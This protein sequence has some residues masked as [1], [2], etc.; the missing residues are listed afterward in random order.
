MKNIRKAILYIICIIFIG[1]SLFMYMYTQKKIAYIDNVYL[2]EHSKIK[3]DLYEKL[4]KDQQVR[5]SILDTIKNNIILVENKLTNDRENKE[6]L[7]QYVISKETFLQKKQKF[8]EELETL[9]RETDNKIWQKINQKIIDFGKEKNY[10]YIL[11]A[12]GQG[13]IMYAKETED[14]TED[15]MKFINDDYEGIKTK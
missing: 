12:N 5:E 11:G 4:K 2:F 9:N 1:V 7:K 8:S 14:I 15:V 10:T 6:L 13:S 3:S